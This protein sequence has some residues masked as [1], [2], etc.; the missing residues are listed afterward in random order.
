MALV[1]SC[2]HLHYTSAETERFR[3]TFHPAIVYL[4]RVH[5]EVLVSQFLGFHWAGG[6]PAAVVY[7]WL[8]WRK[9]SWDAAGKRV[10]IE[11]RGNDSLA[12]S[13]KAFILTDHCPHDS[14]KHNFIHPGLLIACRLR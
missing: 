6:Y 9:L 10:Q 13:I 2:C 7:I 11:S 1:F 4:L 3:F 5:P 12:E 8:S 14:I